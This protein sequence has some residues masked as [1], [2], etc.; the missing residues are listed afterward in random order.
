MRADRLLLRAHQIESAFY[1]AIR[2]EPAD[3]EIRR[4]ELVALFGPAGSGK[5]LMLALI[6]GEV[7]LHAGV[8][9]C[10]DCATAPDLSRPARNTTPLNLL[11]RH[12]ESWTRAI[13]LLELLGLSAVAETPI[14]QLSTS[15]RAM[16]Q[17]A[18]VLAQ[19]GPLYLLDDPFDHADFEQARRLWSELDDRARFGNAVLF[20]TRQPE[21]AQRADRVLMLD[22]GLLLADDAPQNLIEGLNATRIEVELSDPEPLMPMLDG[23]EV[24]LVERADGYH[25]SLYAPDTLALK[26]LREGYG[27]VKTVIVRPPDLAEA[28]HWLRMQTRSRRPAPFLQKEDE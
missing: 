9:E 4:G 13:Y 12:A 24:R 8:L 26:L 1:G 20:T 28:W 21:I 2:V 10:A 25:L 16:L 18:C 17:V 19:R 14:G 27:N 7:P 11:K 6:A 15:Q 3:F 22:N 5:S 23:V